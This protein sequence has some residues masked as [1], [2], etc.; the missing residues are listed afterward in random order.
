MKSFYDTVVVGAGPA[1]LALAH[2][3]SHSGGN[4]NTILVMDSLG[5]IGGCHRVVR[6]PYHGHPLFTEHG[7]R[8]YMGN[9]HNFQ[10]LLEDMGQGW[11]QMFTPYQFSIRQEAMRRSNL[12]YREFAYFVG[13]FLLFLWDGHYGKETTLQQFGEKHHFAP[14]TMDRLDRFTRMTDGAGVDRFT[15]GQLFQAM[16]QNFFYNI[17]QPRH[18]NDKALFPLWEKFLRG[19]GV[20]FALD[21]PVV[22]LRDNKGT[23]TVWAI[24]KKHNTVGVQCGRVVLAVPPHAMA[25]ILRACPKDIRDS[26]LPYPQL[27]RVVEKTDYLPYLSMTLH[28]STRQEAPRVHGFPVG[29]WGVLFV[30]LSDYMDMSGEYSKTLISCCLSY[31]DRPSH[32]TGKT[33]HQSP[34]DEVKQETFRQLRTAMP[35]LP[36]PNTILI[37]PQNTYDHKARRWQQQDVSFFP[38]PS[39]PTIPSQG[40][41][42]GLYNVG[43]QNQKSPYALTTLESA[44]GNALI[45]AHQLDPATQKLY[46]LRSPHTLRTPLRALLFL[47]VVSV[48]ALALA[49]ARNNKKKKTTKRKKK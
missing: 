31:L 8:V 13:A 25:R 29:E 38:D 33:A 37:S 42:P 27:L 16:D 18:P 17:Y 32:H 28:W 6:V 36:P 22:S 15:V 23:H 7:P 34:P 26:F 40:A 2:A 47:L 12:S 3:L 21:H 10:S 46:P 4:N 5:E 30:V 1:G 44:V 49:L 35:L 45:L 43:V 39:A 19:R 14:E 24:D 41:I 48:L 11:D 20:E 9:Y